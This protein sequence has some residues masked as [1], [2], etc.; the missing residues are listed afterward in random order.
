MI[1]RI[2]LITLFSLIAAVSWL[3]A[4]Q[5]DAILER[6][7]ATD[8]NGDGKLSDEEFR[9]FDEKR[10]AVMAKRNPEADKDKNGKVDRAEFLAFMK[11]RGNQ[12]QTPQRK[13][14][15]RPEPTHAD[16]AY[17]DHPQQKFDLWLAK[18]AVEGEPTPLCIF[19]HGGGFRSGSKNQAQGRV[20]Q[21]F[22]DKG[23]SY[24]AL[25]YR[26]T[27]DGEFAYPVPMLDSARGLQTIRSRAAEWN[28]DPEKIA[29]HGGSAG[30]GISLWLG[31][32][33]DMADPDSEDPISR[34]STRIVAAATGNGQ[35][36]YDMRTI[37]EWFGVADLPFEDALIPFYN[38]QEGETAD[39]PRVVKLA[40]DAASI[41]HLTKDD[42]P[43]YMTYSRPNTKVEVDT[44]KMVWIHHPMFGL[45]LQEAMQKLDLECV[46]V[47][48]GQTPEKYRTAED[49]LIEKLLAK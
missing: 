2:H 45:K 33:D 44:P 9:A 48:P 27:N 6:F 30:A 37:R 8:L 24:A 5:R 47:L 21:R 34:Q 25:D 31:F 41:N 28:I 22:L 38:L 43:V 16:I 26:L 32:R 1:T 7:P 10:Q 20:I 12:P 35:S 18:P 36:T 15:G 13:N 17:G 11:T 49:F 46:V 23:I 42:I 19:I 3:P 14:A 40:E 4:Q 29:C 39:T